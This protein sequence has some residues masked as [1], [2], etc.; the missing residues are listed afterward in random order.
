VVWCRS[1]RFISFT[2]TVDRNGYTEKRRFF[3]KN[4]DFSRLYPVH[5]RLP[6]SGTHEKYCVAWA[7]A[8]FRFR[9]Y[10]RLDT[11][12]CFYNLKH[13]NRCDC[14]S[15]RTNGEII[16]G[17]VIILSTRLWNS[18][19]VVGASEWLLAPLLTPVWSGT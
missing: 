13:L 12:H 6:S 4:T 1:R 7:I 14:Q 17:S 11:R 19:C 18:L 16:W 5:E 9:D 8:C 10:I 3:L 2:G 15:R